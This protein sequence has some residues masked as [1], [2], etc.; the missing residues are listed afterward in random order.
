MIELSGLER[1]VGV[2]RRLTTLSTHSTFSGQV[3]EDLLRLRHSTVGKHPATDIL[4]SLASFHGIDI[5]EEFDQL[6]EPGLLVVVERQV[7]AVAGA[8]DQGG[9]RNLR[10]VGGAVPLLEFA[11]VGAPISL[12]PCMGT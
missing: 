1:V 4:S 10:Q 9:N 6:G 7:A 5:L 11:S 8:D 2:V 3:V 12:G